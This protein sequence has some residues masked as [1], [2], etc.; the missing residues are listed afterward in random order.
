MYTALAKEDTETAEQCPRI[1]VGHA[2]PFFL[3]HLTSK[4]HRQAV[5]KGLLYIPSIATVSF[6]AN[7]PQKGLVLCSPTCYEDVHKDVHKVL[8]RLLETC[9]GR[10]WA[11][12]TLVSPSQGKDLLM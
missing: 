6:T 1:A 11:L 7:K 10:S 5:K 12:Q 4:P 3:Q 2:A 9:R 8:K